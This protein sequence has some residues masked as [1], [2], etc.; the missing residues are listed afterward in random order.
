MLRMRILQWM[1]S[2]EAKFRYDPSRPLSRDS[3]LELR[4]HSAELAGE[5]QTALEESITATGLASAG[6][7]Q[8]VADREKTIRHLLV[9]LAAA[10]SALG[11]AGRS[12]GG[13][14]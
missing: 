11:A 7:R 3:L 14:A 8:A 4:Q 12:T 10:K 6:I 13:G 1:D 2:C 9:Q 5:F